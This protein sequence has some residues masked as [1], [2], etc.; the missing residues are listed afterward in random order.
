MNLLYLWKKRDEIIPEPTNNGKKEKDKDEPQP[1]VLQMPF[2]TL[3]LI[4]DLI[5]E[6]IIHQWLLT[7]FH[8]N[9]SLYREYNEKSRSEKGLFIEQNIVIPKILRMLITRRDSINIDKMFPDM[10]KEILELVAKKLLLT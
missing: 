10:Y 5:K 1:P 9:P 2:Q 3:Y 7:E 8:I 4:S 6:D